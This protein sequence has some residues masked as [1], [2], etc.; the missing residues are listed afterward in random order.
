MED[1]WDYGL[2]P[3][4]TFGNQIKTSI[5]AVSGRIDLAAK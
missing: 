2:F 5:L 1:M 3:T 4:Y